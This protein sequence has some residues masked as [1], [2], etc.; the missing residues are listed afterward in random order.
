[1]PA[2][3]AHWLILAAALLADGG[4]ATLIT[5]AVCQAT[6]TGLAAFTDDVLCANSA[7][8]WVSQGPVQF[9]ACS[10]SLFTALDA[11]T[12]CAEYSVAFGLRAGG[13]REEGCKAILSEK[14][15]HVSEWP[16]GAPTLGVGVGAGGGGRGWAAALLG[17]HLLNLQEIV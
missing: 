14:S 7:D 16:G 13:S 6:L 8:V 12:T 3:R 9:P 11:V 17:A 10:S 4:N 5:Y 15:C 1:M 2:L